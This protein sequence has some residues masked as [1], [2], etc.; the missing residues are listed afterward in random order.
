MFINLRLTTLMISST[1][2][3]IS[4]QSLKI[5]RICF[6]WILDRFFCLACIA[7]ACK[8]SDSS[9]HCRSKLM[10]FWCHLQVNKC[11]DTHATELV[12]DCPTSRLLLP[13]RQLQ[14]SRSWLKCF[15]HL[16]IEFKS[17][18][19]NHLKGGQ[20]SWFRCLWICYSCTPS[21]QRIR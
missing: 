18:T 2:W 8:K 15:Q 5:T 20:W 9:F 13:F 7:T 6:L 10:D 3:S 12:L 1:F 14:Q 21:S 19:Q 17:T 4:W 11:W 16:K